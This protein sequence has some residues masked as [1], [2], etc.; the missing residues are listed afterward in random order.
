MKA[1]FNFAGIPDFDDHINLSIPDYDKLFNLISLL[2]LEYLQSDGRCVDLGCATGKLLNAISSKVD[3]EF[4][5]V[6]AVTFQ[7]DKQFTFIQGDC[8]DYLSKLDYADMLVSVFTLQFLDNRARIVALEQI[9]RLIDK[10][11]VFI[12]AEKI[13]MDSPRLNSIF[14]KILLEGKRVNFSDKEILDKDYSLL[15]SMYCRTETEI[16]KE[17]N[18]LGQSQQVWQSLNFKAWL[19]Q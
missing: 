13:Y 5:G 11:A 4:I 1:K 12:F 3:A 18:L 10:G 19:I 9:K 15:G 2:A 8:V 14:Q 7:G 17:N 6:D 16:N